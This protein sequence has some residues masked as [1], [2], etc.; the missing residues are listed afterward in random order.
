MEIKTFLKRNLIII[1]TVIF[2][3]LICGIPIISRICQDNNLYKTMIV[4]VENKNWTDAKEK[5][6]TLKLHGI[7]DC[8]KYEKTIY[9]N[10]YIIQ[11]DMYY[12]KNELREALKDYK[13]ALTFNVNDKKLEEKI[14]KLEK[15]CKRL[16]EIEYKK[17][18]Q[19]RIKAEQEQKRKEQQEKL[20]KQHELKDL[21]NMVNNAFINIEL[22]NAGDSSGTGF[23]F[24]TY[25]NAWN[26][27][28]YQEQ[29]DVFNSCVR[30]VELKENVSYYI[31]NKYTRI[32]SVE[33]KL[34]MASSYDFTN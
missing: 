18:E 9:Y 28:N 32:I 16:D 1:C 34:P 6:D 11:G 23:N 14:K 12:K 3:F 25:R 22:F 2:I 5:L 30:Y 8:T 7:L 13:Y 15:E 10:Y 27:L 29:K 33:S 26:D 21:S 19:E 17:A 4:D 24:Y 20:K 31:A